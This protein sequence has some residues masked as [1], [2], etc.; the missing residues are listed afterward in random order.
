MTSEQ[1]GRSTVRELMD[2]NAALAAWQCIHTDGKTGLTH[3][4]WANASCAKDATIATLTAENERLSARVARLEAAL[5]AVRDDLN[6]RAVKGVVAVG[7]SVWLQI[8]R[9]LE[10]GK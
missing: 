3:D 10:E 9:E 5:K 4:D 1:T 2:E 8:N 6:I 7:N